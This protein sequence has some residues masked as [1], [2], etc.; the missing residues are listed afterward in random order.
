MQSSPDSAMNEEEG[1]DAA[2]Q[3]VSQLLAVCECI[4][5]SAELF[6]PYIHKLPRRE[7]SLKGDEVGIP[8]CHD[9]PSC[10][11]FLANEH[12]MANGLE[13]IILGHDPISSLEMHFCFLPFSMLHA[14]EPA[15]LSHLDG[16]KS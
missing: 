6:T 2:S 16:T 11:L 9:N 10:G 15:V 7:I 4:S 13:A 14:V 1:M 12:L 8:E 3:R 5:S